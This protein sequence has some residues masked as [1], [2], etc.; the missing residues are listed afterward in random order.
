M[1][2]CR[3][4]LIDGMT[5]EAWERLAEVRSGARHEVRLRGLAGLELEDVVLDARV[6]ILGGEFVAQSEYEARALKPI[7]VGVRDSIGDH[8]I[9]TTAIENCARAALCNA[10]GRYGEARASAIMAC[11]DDNARVTVWALAELIEASCRHG[12]LDD[13]AAILA[14]P[15]W[16]TISRVVAWAPGLETRSRA[17]LSDDETAEPLFR[18]SLEQLSCAH[19]VLHLARTHLLYGEW[20]RRANRRVHARVQLRAALQLFIEMGLDPF[21]ERARRELAATCE[22]ARKRADSTRDVL[23]AQEEQIARLAGDGCTNPEIAAELFISRRTVEWHLRKV[24]N[25][26]GITSRRQL[27]G[28]SPAV[29]GLALAAYPRLAEVALETTR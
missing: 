13:S 22:T 12:R 18:T 23:T 8:A 20:L 25:K 24:F 11:D 17:L 29:E 19:A 10:L 6:R 2:S 15:E 26:L 21:A 27:R 28:R 5:S 7:E 9:S 3:V 16:K 14:R 1:S 4:V